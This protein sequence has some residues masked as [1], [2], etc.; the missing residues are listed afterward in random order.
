L[1]ISVQANSSQHPQIA[2]AKGTEGDAQA[3]DLLCKCEALNSNPSTTKIK[4]VS[5]KLSDSFFF[6]SVSILIRVPPFIPL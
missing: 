1:R 5:G 4:R 3:E 6:P 2:R